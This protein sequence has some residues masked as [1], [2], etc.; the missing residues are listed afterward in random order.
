MSDVY[1]KA[2]PNDGYDDKT[3]PLP[4]AV[5]TCPFCGD[6]SSFTQDG[7][8]WLTNNK[9]HVGPQQPRKCVRCRRFLCSETVYTHLSQ[10]CDSCNELWFVRPVNIEFAGIL[11]KSR[12]PSGRL[13]NPYIVTAIF[14]FATFLGSVTY[15]AFLR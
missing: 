14:M 4:A 5:D 12:S 2:G 8:I 15:Y 13:S 11:L 1:R 9:N 10:Q 3:H 7:Y 6:E